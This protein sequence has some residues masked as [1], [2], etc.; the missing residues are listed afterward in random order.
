MES[1][2]EILMQRDGMARKEV[3]DLLRVVRKECFE[4]IENGEDPEEV[5]MYS[6]GLE[7][8]YLFDVLYNF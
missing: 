7:P 8:D 2:V 1:V 3:L 5:L 6:I 4:A